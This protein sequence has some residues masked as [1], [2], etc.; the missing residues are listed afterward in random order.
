MQGKRLGRTSV[1]GVLK[2]GKELRQKVGR[3]SALNN[4]A[5]IADLAEG[6]LCAAMAWSGHAIAA[7]AS[8][9]S[10]AFIVPPEGALL[11]LDAWAIPRDAQ[12][13]ELAH[14]FIDYMLLPYHA[15]KNSLATNFYPP[16]RSDLRELVELAELK[17]QLVPSTV[18]RRR[19]YFLESLPQNQKAALIQQWSE[20]KGTRWQTRQAV[21]KGL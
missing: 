4:E 18:Y 16:L 9:P 17:P 2:A 10:L 5:Y 20:I 14:L 21:A 7:S 13:P 11:T 3:L 15:K 6:R 1:R 12:N 8:R 19:L